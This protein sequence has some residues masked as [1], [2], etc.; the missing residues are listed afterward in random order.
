[1]TYS[2][3]LDKI[4]KIGVINMS[5]GKKHKTISV[6]LIIISVL[7]VAFIFSQS[8]L[9]GKVSGEESGRVLKFLNDIL[10]SIGMPPFLTHSFVRTAA[11]FSEFAALG[12]SLFF[13][14][15]SFGKKCLYSALVSLSSSLFVACTDECI[16]LFSEGRA[17]QLS[18][19]L[20]DFLGA[21][22]AVFLLYSL[23]YIISFIKRKRSDLNE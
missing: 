3:K 18:D 6:V 5:T 13:T 16:Q 14:A 15:V 20:T 19:I 11:H 4:V 1:M 7:I 12:T 2:L 23:F 10:A 22:L 17:F 9:P 21:F 8:L